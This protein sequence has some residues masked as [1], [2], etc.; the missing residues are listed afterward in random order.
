VGFIE[1]TETNIGMMRRFLS[2]PRLKVCQ[3]EKGTL[4][5]TNVAIMYLE[6]YVDPELLH[7]VQD[8]IKR[9]DIENLLDGAQLMKKII[10]QPR[11]IFP[12]VYETE[13]LDVASFALSQGKIVV[14]VD[15]STFASILPIT[16]FNLIEVSADNFRIPW[17]LTFIRLLR[18]ISMIVATL[19]PALYVSLVGFHPE[20]LPTTLALTIAESRNNIPFP[21]F[22][23]ALFMIFA[24]DILV[25]ASIRLPSN[26][27][28]TI[29]IV[30]GLVMGQA[31]VEAG[32]VSTTMII[33]SS[34]TAISSF[35][36]P[37]WQLI[38]AWRLVRYFLLFFSALLGLYG[39]V[40]GVGLVVLH[41]CHLRSFS[42]PY[43]SPLSPFNRKE[44][45][46]M[47]FRG[48]FLDK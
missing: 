1:D 16:L 6:E 38:S 26:V 28:Q 14:F 47:I 35:T 22:T 21:V 9:L 11:S 36:L 19:L 7:T 3:M 4:S 48:T 44:F 31:A 12:Q 34:A 27:G 20:L 23:E 33:V 24:L 46:N 13:R 43:L 40:L 29:G 39:L 32:L 18:F 45:M 37:T 25:E 10:E 8:R 30:G 17:D 2:D 15:H 41:L 5:H 42:I